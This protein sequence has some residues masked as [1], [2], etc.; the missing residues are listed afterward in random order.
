[1][2]SFESPSSLCFGE[3]QIWPRRENIFL[4]N[5][6]K[7]NL[8]CFA[9]SSKYS[10]SLNVPWG[11]KLAEQGI[12]Y[13]LSLDLLLI[14]AKGISRSHEAVRYKELS[15][16]SSTLMLVRLNEWWRNDCIIK[17]GCLLPNRNYCITTKTS[18]SLRSTWPAVCSTLCAVF[19][20]IVRCTFS[21]KL[22]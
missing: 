18:L 8:D 22:Y 13:V 21:W 15:I 7:T 1:M 17:K 5:L 14:A 12:P 19:L 3:R 4:D 11:Q 2:A 20:I 9:L 10:G 6:L 16:W